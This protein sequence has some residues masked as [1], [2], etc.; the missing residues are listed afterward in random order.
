MKLHTL[1]FVLIASL[2]LNFAC[3]WAA[4]SVP[5]HCKANEYSIASAWMAKVTPSTSGWASLRSGKFFSLCSDKIKEPFRYVVYRYGSTGHVDLEATATRKLPF[6]I[7]QGPP[8]HT[9]SDEVI[10][11]S[12][13]G[14][15]YEISIATGMGSGIF[16]TVHNKSG[17]L[18]L[19]HFSGN[20]LGS[21]YM[22]GPAQIDFT[23]P[24][25]E[26]PVLSYD[27]PLFGI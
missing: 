5:T 25:A 12:R 9:G 27:P 10:Y 11:F 22:L 6:G 20:S 24:N 15:T 21:D 23:G 18:V 4:I 26:S 2:P 1:C 17:K 19:S 13:G 14:Y 16:L 3:A 8:T 7:F